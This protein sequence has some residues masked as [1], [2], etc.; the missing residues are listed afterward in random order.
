MSELQP[1]LSRLRAFRQSFEDGEIC[2]ETG[3][4]TEDLDVILKAL[5]DPI[6]VH[7][8]RD[9]TGDVLGDTA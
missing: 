5:E 1:S 2:E 8:S 4:T 7:A 9:A 3:L 6:A